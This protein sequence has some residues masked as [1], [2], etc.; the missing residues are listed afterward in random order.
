MKEM[1]VRAGRKD[2]VGSSLPEDGCGVQ[3]WNCREQLE[4]SKD[5]AWTGVCLVRG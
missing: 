4:G 5:P 2:V 1:V 3:L